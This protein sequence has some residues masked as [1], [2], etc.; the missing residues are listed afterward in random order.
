MSLNPVLANKIFIEINRAAAARKSAAGRQFWKISPK[1]PA[2]RAQKIVEMQG[3]FLHL[4]AP[5]MKTS[6]LDYELPADRIA[7][8][9]SAERDE[10]RLLV[11]D[12][13]TGKTEHSVFKNLPDF[14]GGRFDF[15]RNDASV[16]KGRI[17]A[18]KSTG[19]QVE[20]LLLRP[21]DSGDPAEWNC[22]LKPGKRL[23]PGAKFGVEG[24]FEAE[25]LEKSDGGIAA[26]RF[27]T[28][29]CGG[30]EAL[31]ERLGVVPLPP[32]IA[33]DQRSPGYDKNFDNERYQTV[34]ADSA[35]RVAAAAPTAGLHFTK[36]LQ[37]RLS[38]AGSRFFNLTLHV[39]M[40]TFQPVKCDAVEDH[41]MHSEVYEIPADTLRAMFDR[42][43]PNLAVGTTSL[44]AME[45]FYRKSGKL[46]PNC[47]AS[48][49]GSAD[50]FVYPPQTLLSADA[51]ITNFHLPRSTLMCLVGAF[52][53]PGGRD[54]IKILKEIYA[55]AVAKGYSFY[56]YGDAMLVL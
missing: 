1:A 2:K 31:S 38:A 25:V 30:V 49:F 3:D 55:A 5:C 18:K 32:Y 24:E 14:V 19:G 7:R 46:P 15:F 37:D 35:K 44:R 4:T 23:G 33:R 43:R 34:Y 16:L 41:K 27:S 52:I 11:Y 10:C 40:G 51:L 17:F 48:V 20:C 36:E 39:G 26:V 28:F 53:S 29:S 42:R 50:I 12:R 22:M 13:K 8:Y 45:D 56:S 6:D 9:P 54:G 47:A 21:A